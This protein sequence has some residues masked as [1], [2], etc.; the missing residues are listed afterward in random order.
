MG[1]GKGS[2]VLGFW[3]AWE[4]FARLPSFLDPVAATLTDSSSFFFKQGGTEYTYVRNGD[5]CP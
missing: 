5:P 2:G 4:E 1:D 3:L